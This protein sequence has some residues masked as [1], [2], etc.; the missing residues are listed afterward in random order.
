MESTFQ[1]I[2]HGR[3]HPFGCFT[4]LLCCHLYH[5]IAAFFKWLTENKNKTKQNRSQTKPNCKQMKVSE[6]SQFAEAKQLRQLVVAL[7]SIYRLRLRLRLQIAFH[8]SYSLIG[9]RHYKQST[10]I[11]ITTSIEPLNFNHRRRFFPFSLR[12]FADI[13]SL[14]CVALYRH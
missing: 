7:S 4:V 5:K 2:P 9:R 6:V 13:F 3:Q 12:F 11:Q 14:S 10:P 1:C 8:F